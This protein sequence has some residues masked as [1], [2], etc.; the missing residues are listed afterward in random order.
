MV[1]VYG[2]E[3]DRR[4]GEGRGGEGMVYVEEVSILLSTTDL[5]FYLP[6]IVGTTTLRYLGVRLTWRRLG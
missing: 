5:L 4:G 1:I 3:A 6:T 2:R